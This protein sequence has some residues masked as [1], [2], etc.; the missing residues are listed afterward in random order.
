MQNITMEYAKDQA[1]RAVVALEEEAR[2]GELLFL[3]VIIKSP[4]K[5]TVFLKYH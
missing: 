2:E 3:Q 4:L 5:V 1:V